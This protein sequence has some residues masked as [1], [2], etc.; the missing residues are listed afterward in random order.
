MSG[1]TGGSGEHQA[2]ESVPDHD[3]HARFAE[4]FEQIR[5]GAAMR[6]RERQHPFEEMRA[7]RESGFG[8]LRLP[9]SL[10][11]CGASLR[12]LFRMLVELGA[13][14]SNLPQALRQH[15]F[16]V[17]LLL[18]DPQA[19]GNRIWLERVAAGALFGNGTTEPQGSMLGQVG[20][21]VTGNP[22]DGYRLDGHKIYCTGNLYAQWIPVAAV[23]ETGS[24]LVV[25]VPADRP[26]LEIRDD[27][28]GFGQRLTATGSTVFDAVEVF[29]DEIV[30]Y[31]DPSTHHGAGFHQLVLVATLAGIAKAARNDLVPRLR[32]RRRIY[33]TGTGVLPRHD[34]IIQEA[35]G[36]IEASVQ[37][38]VA[39]TDLA[40]GILEQA[41]TSW[42]SQENPDLVERNFIAADISI[43]AAQV[44]LSQLV[45][46]ITGRI[47]DTM[48]ASSTD[49]DL[50][51]DR[52]W[53]N[54]RTVACHN[55]HLFKARMI[56]DHVLN[57]TAPPIFR[58]GHD[59]GDKAQVANAL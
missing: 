1:C 38:S 29:E 18:L 40:A 50:G 34:P 2:H 7:L 35:V 55:P 27:W 9:I 3:L 11:G 32:D 21:R 12:Q 36:M 16:R 41:W 43:G 4:I 45:V 31:P 23:D 30:Q 54:A 42:T 19:D 15:F 51:L 10:G 49:R 58:P 37:A 46:E 56:G 13:A 22:A 24:P 17:E 5:K 6:D 8:A 26:G 52:H 28:T 25:V 59:V 20:T 14:D 48:G 53:R 47:F 33:Y 39:T 44:T 57:G